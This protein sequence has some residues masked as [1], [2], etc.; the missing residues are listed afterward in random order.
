MEWV[1]KQPLFNHFYKTNIR[2]ACM[3]CPITL[4]INYANLLKYYPDIFE[5]MLERMRENEKRQVELGRHFLVISSNPKYNVEYLN[6]VR[7]KWLKILNE[8]E[9]RRWDIF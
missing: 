5:Y 8:K 6:N 7:A 2:C 1:R 4:Y 9:H 3:Y